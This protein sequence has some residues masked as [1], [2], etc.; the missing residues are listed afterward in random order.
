MTADPTFPEHS[1]VRTLA[2]LEA[3]DSDVIPAGVEGYVVHIHAVPAGVE[4][5]YTV[6]VIVTNVD[7]VQVDAWL[8]EARQ[9]QLELVSDAEA[10]AAHVIRASE[11]ATCSRCGG[12]LMITVE[13]CGT[14]GTPMAWPV[15]C[16][17]C[18][19]RNDHLAA[20]AVVAPRVEAIR[21][22]QPSGE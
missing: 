18:G 20:G 16:P 2:P 10:A 13:R 3:L 14:F 17:L 12:L 4:P 8:L 9:A 5:A 1:A 15:K 19:G 11:K 21:I 7:G 6:E 22:A